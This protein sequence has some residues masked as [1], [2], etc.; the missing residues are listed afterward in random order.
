MDSKLARRMAYKK[1]LEEEYRQFQ[2]RCQVRD[3]RN[4]RINEGK[5]INYP[6]FS[7]GLVTQYDKRSSWGG[8]ETRLC[9]TEQ[10]SYQEI[11]LRR[12]T[13]VRYCQETVSPYYTRCLF[14]LQQ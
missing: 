6:K 12:R 11:S 7:T 4:L 2:E 14:V 9:D 13:G 8:Y 10:W 5:S 3:R 1:K